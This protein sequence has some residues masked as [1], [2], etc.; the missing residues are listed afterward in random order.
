[1]PFLKNIRFNILVKTIAVI[2][3]CGVATTQIQ[4]AQ[5]NKSGISESGRIHCSKKSLEDGRCVDIKSGKD[6]RVFRI[7]NNSLNEQT[8][9]ASLLDGGKWIITASHCFMDGGYK[10]TNAKSIFSAS[11]IYSNRLHEFKFKSIKHSEKNHDIALVELD[12]IVPWIDSEQKHPTFFELRSLPMGSNEIAREIVV[13]GFGKTELKEN[14]N[15][16]RLRKANMTLSRYADGDNRWCIGCIGGSSDSPRMCGG[17]SGGPVLMRAYFP[18]DI[19]G[20]DT[21][22]N[23]TSTNCRGTSSTK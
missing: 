20:I 2:F 13:Y 5:E 9:T 11:V 22:I 12:R 16:Y 15:T 14:P 18:D 21:S 7:T 8:C 17:D 3:F 4:A 6:I 10:I 19:I 1:M 23:D